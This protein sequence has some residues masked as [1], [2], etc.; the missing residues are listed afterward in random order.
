VLANDLR[1][2]SD[3]NDQASPAVAY[4]SYN[5]KYLT[6]WTDLRNGAN[7]FDLYGAICT[8]S[9]SGA[10][11]SMTCGAN[12]PINTAPG[13]QT[14][15]KVAFYPSGAGS[16]FLVV[17]KDESNP[18]YSQ[19]KGQFVLPNGTLVAGGP[20]TISNHDTTI[21]AANGV[22]QSDP[23]V[24]YY[25]SLNKFIVVWVDKSI[26]DTSSNPN[27]TMTLRGGQCSNSTTVSYIPMPV[28]D[29]NLVR[30]VE[31]DP[32]TGARTNQKNIS[33]LLSTGSLADS[34]S[35]ITTKWITQSN[36]SSPK[37]ISDTT[38]AWSGQAQTVTMTVNYKVGT[39][40][41]GATTGV[42]AYNLPVFE[43]VNED[44]NLQKIK[45]RRNEGFGQAFDYSFGVGSAM[46]LTTATDPNTNRTLLAWEEEQQIK[47][48]LIDN[49]SYIQY[50]LVFPYPGF[51]NETKNIIPISVGSTGP[52][53]AP[54]AAFD[55]SNSRFL[56]TWEDG[57]NGAATISNIDIYAQFIEP[58]GA[59]SGGNTIVT[60]SNGNQLAPAVAFGDTEFPDFLVVWKDANNP[61][62]GDIYGQLLEWSTLPQLSI[63]DAN[64]VPILNG[65]IDFGSV[66]IA[67][68][69]PYKDFFFKIRNDGNIALTLSFTPGDDPAAPFSLMTPRPVSISPGTSVDMTVRFAP[70]GSGS[71]SGYQMVFNSDGGKAIIGL[72]GRG[73]GT[74]PLTVTTTSLPD[75]AAGSAYTATLSASGGIVPYSS[76]TKTSGNLPPGLALSTAGVISGTIDP[77]ANGTYTFEVTTRDSSSTVS[78]PKSLSINVSTVTIVNTSPLKSWTVGHAGPPAY[79]EIFSA[80]GGAGALTWS[81]SSG[82]GAGTLSPVPGL[83]LNASTGELSGT[84][85]AAGNFTFTLK[86]TDS[87]GKTASKQFTV[88]VNSAL[89]IAT[90]SLPATIVNQTYSQTVAARGGTQPYT[91]SVTGTLPPGFDPI[92]TSTGAITGMA[93]S[94]G[95]FNF[96]VNVTDN[97]GAT[98]TRP[99]SITINP[100]LDITT[101]EGALPN[102]TS[103]QSYTT[104]LRASGGSNSYEWSLMPGSVLPTGMTLDAIGTIRGTPTVPSIY[105]FTIV[106][107]DRLYLNTV[108]KTYNITVVDPTA[109][110][111]TTLD[112]TNQSGATLT[113]LSFSDTNVF[114]GDIAKKSVTVTNT[115]PN[116]VTV[117]S[118]ASSNS[119][120]FT[121]LPAQFSLAGNASTTFGVSFMPNSI[122]NFAGEL[123]LT[124][125]NGIQYKLGLTGS[126]SPLKVS[127]AGAN[128]TVGTVTSLSSS[129][130]PVATIPPNVNVTG[131]GEFTIT[132]LT[133][134]PA[135]VTLTF[136]STVFPAA[137]LFYSINSSGT[138]T[139]LT[140]TVA[141][142]TFTY[143]LPDND[144]TMD[145][146]S[147]PNSIR[148]MI[149]VGTTG[150]TTTGGTTTG[151]P[152]PSSGGGGGG[153]F[154]A[155]AAYGSYLDP[156][157]MVL[158]H[159]RDNVLLQ[160]EA[161][162]A[163]VKFYYKHS[164]P[165]A[166]FIAQHDTLRMFM[167]LALTPLIFAVKYPLAFM[168]LFAI[169]SGSLLARRIRTKLPEPEQAG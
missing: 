20:I 21:T 84:P 54:V 96:T 65:A 161:G 73:I 74:L 94:A 108:Y 9:G 99:M 113:T 53:T 44:A 117:S 39:I 139:Q 127:S 71:Y 168:L 165:I 98:A 77:T 166:D 29:N 123:T 138:W 10:A 87:V 81:I 126:G 62:N 28:V 78:A 95:T 128:G 109:S 160:S 120:F 48:T 83:T 12:F 16:K 91:W 33:P 112:F 35:S 148:S 89:S 64:D 136:D 106:V 5:N 140:G 68:T 72:S 116:T 158:R 34:G 103:G 125:T 49:N 41:P 3:P 149:A 63:T 30:S 27:N 19:I 142:N 6:V 134:S 69:P 124:D 132:G 58:T 133:S 22:S 145:R 155:T 7:N 131:A 61:A 85:T 101:P 150:T 169:G 31:I 15:V 57:R 52:R 151:V 121:D 14:Q 100:S 156:H 129:Q 162:T 153:C 70:T 56:V 88:P 118:V 47:G 55:P 76:W 102:A 67:Q 135:T 60:V 163:F 11:T 137:P 141:G 164:P 38:A 23:D 86:V 154:I 114:V 79:S 107:K 119:A 130:L 144:A 157:V 13:N 59:L 8:G 32:L 159:F 66:D 24:V 92:D 82:S 147:T 152:Q 93:S 40:A 37:I 2:T 122:T 75:G 167:R 80:T 36:E 146:D 90:T 45:I 46:Y 104:V 105:I 1:I 110:G 42:C 25:P 17:W 43:G 143:A 4:D 51:P 50:P 115:S 111:S 97:V 18:G 26:F